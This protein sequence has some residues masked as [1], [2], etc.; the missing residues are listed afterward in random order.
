M[1]GKTRGEEREPKHEVKGSRGGG[2]ERGS[3]KIGGEKSK[4]V[5]KNREVGRRGEVL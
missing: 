1:L 4:G 2:F 5:R 3:G